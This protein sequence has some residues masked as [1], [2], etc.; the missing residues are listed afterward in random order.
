MKKQTIRTRLTASLAAA[1]LA[2]GTL[3]A[4]PTTMTA[5]AAGLTGKDARGITSQMP[6]SGSA[7]APVAASE[8]VTRGWP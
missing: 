2:A 5:D 1:A 8:I 6:M 7:S 3:A 4:M